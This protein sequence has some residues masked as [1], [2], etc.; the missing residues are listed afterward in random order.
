MRPPV[1]LAL[2]RMLLVLALAA[3]SQP[4]PAFTDTIMPDWTPGPGLATP[5]SGGVRASALPPGRQRF[6]LGIQGCLTVV[7]QPHTGKND[8]HR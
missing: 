7:Q 5:S 2:P 6:L 3:C 1:L 4:T 8:S